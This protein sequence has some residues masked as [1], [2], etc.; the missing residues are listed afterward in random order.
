M[1]KFRLLPPAEAI[2]TAE[3]AQSLVEELRGAKIL[4]VDTETTGLNRPGDYAIILAVSDGER[5]WAIW[6]AGIPAFQDL[7]ENPEVKLILHNANFDQWM[8]RNAGIDLDRHA[9]PDHY[10]VYDTMVMHALLH[11]HAP[12]DLKTLAREYLGIE[13]IPFS[14]VFSKDLR[15]RRDGGHKSLEDVLLAPENRDTVLN[16]AALDAYA[17]FLLFVELREELRL[18]KITKWGSPY[19]SLWDYYLQTEVPFTKVLWH[20]ELA[21]VSIDQEDL[22]ARKPEL[23][24]KI[25]T[26][27]KWFIKETGNLSINLKS[28]PQLSKLF[29]ETF[30]YTPFSYTEKGA[31]Q[32]N[33]AA[34]ERWATDGCEFSR[35]LLEHRDLHKKLKTYV[36]GILKSICVRTGRLHATFNQTGARTG[37]LSS[38]SP[39]LQNQPAYIRSAYIAKP[40]HRLKV[41]DYAQLEMR[42]L[43]HVSRDET[44]CKA[45][46]SGQDVHTA[47]AAKMFKVPY[48]DIMEARRID[49][50]PEGHPEKYELSDYQNGLLLKRKAAKTINF[51]LMY[52]Q[53]PG[54]LAFSLGIRLD[55]AKKFID[56]Y[57]KTFPKVTTYFSRAIDAATT[58][59]YC[60]T[61]LGRRRLVPNLLSAIRGD[62]AQ[63]KRKVKNSPIQG[64]AADITKMA[65]LKLWEDPLIRA[66]GAKMLVQVHD[67]VVIEVP[68]EFE[69][70]DAFNHRVRDLMEHPLPFDLEVPLEITTKYAQNWAEAK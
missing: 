34:L 15:K 19:D 23:E 41:S 43:A 3:A 28:T 65:M 52:G 1:S 31:P 6:P 13:M 51:G 38:S 36:I 25:L 40:G 30:N 54:K 26:L 45:I 21:G 22:L 70:N 50:L 9:R 33:A 32:L 60:Q 62:A 56:Q 27:E 46:L 69:H 10:R 55:E 18:A 16:Y 67:E 68:E 59:G 49:D 17:T 57:F 61:V 7:L 53:G 64:S 12:H 44:L 48:G 8:L 11:D 37:R 20:M 4:A 63:A 24:A 29:F 39:N 47:T 14:T 35:N 2:E 66:S 42:I 5:R 58:V